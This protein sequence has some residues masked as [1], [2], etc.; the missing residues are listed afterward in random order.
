MITPELVLWQEG[1]DVECDLND[2]GASETARVGNF[3][4]PVAAA[5]TAADRLQMASR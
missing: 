4:N 5:A 1:R 2:I 3:E